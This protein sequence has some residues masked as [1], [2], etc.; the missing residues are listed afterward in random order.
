MKGRSGK[1]TSLLVTLILAL[2]LLAGCATPAATQIPPDT[3]APTDA[4]ASSAASGT[5]EASTAA[6]GAGDSLSWMQD[7]SPVAFDLFINC[8]W[9]PQPKNPWGVD[10]VSKVIL[11]KTGV[12]VNVKC[13]TDW[14]SSALNALIAANDLP[15]FTMIADNQPVYGTMINEGLVY[16]IN[17][18]T[19]NYCPEYWDMLPADMKAYWQVA[20]GNVYALP[21]DYTDTEKLIA[22][23]NDPKT[24]DLVSL[25]PAIFAINTPIWKECGSPSMATLEDYKAALL[26]VKEKRPDV[27]FLCYPAGASVGISDYRSM[28]Q[29]VNRIYGGTDYHSIAPDGAVRL[30]I[31]DDPF[32]KAILYM[33]DLYLSGL[34]NPEVYTIQDEQ[35]KQLLANNKIFSYWLEALWAYQLDKTPG[36]AYDAF[37]PPQEPNIPFKIRM[38][39]VNLGGICT[40]ITKKCDKPDRAIRYLEFLYSDEGSKL[41]MWGP[42]PDAYT[43]NADGL[44]VWSVAH[45]ADYNGDWSKA[46]DK[47]QIGS[48]VT[49]W[50]TQYY[51]QTIS[52]IGNYE[53]FNQKDRSGNRIY[54]K[55]ADYEFFEC[56]IKVPPTDTDTNTIQ[57]QLND[58]SKEYEPKMVLAKSQEECLAMYNEYLSKADMLGL[59]RLEE[60]LTA[61]CRELKSILN[62]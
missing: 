46:N 41:T 12:S 14:D 22:L 1:T 16:S 10:E 47:W 54:N 5:P 59:A 15:D 36:G 56:A 60:V 25:A 57:T 53:N 9:V 26:T 34:I 2:G 39:Q 28:V 7:T 23:S 58:L 48:F 8:G 45:R 40:L 35:Y 21:F 20:D 42:T 37:E 51:L 13:T 29:V 4:A 30:N 44:P 11:Q 61:R 18:L 43:L 19:S 62:K 52:D 27:T 55:Y 50:T 33:N 3:A 49:G 32:K 6:S 24:A 17:E 31:R 38:N